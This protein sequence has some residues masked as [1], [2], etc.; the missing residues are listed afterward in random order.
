MGERVGG[1]QRSW[2]AAF[3][4]F[5]TGAIRRRARLP[6]PHDRSDLLDER[7]AP[8]SRS[9][10]F[11]HKAAIELPADCSFNAAHSADVGDNVLA[12]VDRVTRRSDGY[13]LRRDID[14]RAKA[15]A[16]A[17][18]PVATRQREFNALET[19]ILFTISV[20]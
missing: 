14:G 17:V 12:D 9:R 19:A 4:R 8:L 18:E 11:Y 2:L 15:F 6:A 16:T 5:S 1:H 3:F 7:P 10:D 20:E 13:A